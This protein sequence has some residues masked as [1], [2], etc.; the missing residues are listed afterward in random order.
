MLITK[1]SLSILDGTGP[2]PM[3]PVLALGSI[4][5]TNVDS[6]VDLHA[7]LGHV[8]FNRVVHLL[9]GGVVVDAKKINARRGTNCWRRSV[10]SVSVELARRAR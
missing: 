10:E 4:V 6:L 8:S 9:K 1:N 7:R 5:G 3:H 2:V